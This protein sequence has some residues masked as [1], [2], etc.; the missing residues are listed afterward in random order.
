[1]SD[2]ENYFEKEERIKNELIFYNPK[3]DEWG[4]FVNNRLLEILAPFKIDH[5]L[6]IE[7][8]PRLKDATSYLVKALYR[9]VYD[10][11]IVDI[12][13]K[14]GT[15]IVL[16][17]T[18]DV[19]EVKELIS[20]STCWVSKIGKDYKEEI[21]KAPEI[22]A[23]QSVHLVVSPCDNYD[24]SDDIKAVLTCE[25]QIRTLLQHA[26]AEI[27]HDSSY[28]GPYKND[29]EMLRVLAKSMALMEAT[30]EYFLDI[31]DMMSDESRKYRNY[32]N[33]LIAKYSKI[34]PSYNSSNLQ[35]DLND[36]LFELL[37]KKDVSIQEIDNFIVQ[38]EAWLKSGLLE[39]NGIL[40]KQPIIILLAYYLHNYEKFLRS[41]WPLPEDLLKNLFQS[42]GVSFSSY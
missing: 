34:V 10:N 33:E 12:E 18:R 5:R 1:M 6:K 26:Y 7:P 17:T 16:L 4:R 22:F 28:K 36:T 31:F 27:S 32:L 19:Y 9:K 21:L 3:I 24:V 14:V 29:R 30:D 15:R 41:E 8:S 23:Y 42:F 20:N 35:M 13:D 25:I 38:E 37:K 40:F 2:I 11:P 39:K